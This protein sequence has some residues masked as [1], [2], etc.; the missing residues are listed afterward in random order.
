VYGPE[1]GGR[2][3][4]PSLRPLV[5]SR[6]TSSVDGYD[7]LTCEQFREPLIGSGQ[8]RPVAFTAR[9]DARTLLLASDGLLNYTTAQ[10]ITN[11][12]ANEEL[13]GLSARLVDLVRLRSGSLHDDVAVVLA[14]AGR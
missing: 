11:L 5:C 1:D 10:R 14:R 7:A 3:V 13:A 4:G 12:V 9:L 6:S 8:A 2:E